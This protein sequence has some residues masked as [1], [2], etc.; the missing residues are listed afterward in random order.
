LGGLSSNDGLS[1]C[2]IKHS[3]LFIQRKV[4]LSVL[5]VRLRLASEC[6]NPL[7]DIGNSFLS[8]EGTSFEGSWTDSLLDLSYVIFPLWPGREG[9][10][11]ILPVYHVVLPTVSDGMMISLCQSYEGVHGPFSD[12]L[13]SLY[14]S[15][16]ES[17]DLSSDMMQIGSSRLGNVFNAYRNSP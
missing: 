14:I 4:A 8:F 15:P 1:K 3:P 17:K 16:N 6:A 7:S 2:D 11:V 10:G 9:L 5:D 13:Q 12:G